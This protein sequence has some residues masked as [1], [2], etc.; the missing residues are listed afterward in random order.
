MDLKAFILLI[1]L[2]MTVVA[3]KCMAQENMQSTR[4]SHKDPPHDQGGNRW[5][6]AP[7]SC[8]KTESMVMQ[9]NYAHQTVRGL[10]R[11]RCSLV[12]RHY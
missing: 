12:T 11:A 4:S 1:T 6:K 3:W 7:Q 9:V 10:P 5:V 8:W 2:L